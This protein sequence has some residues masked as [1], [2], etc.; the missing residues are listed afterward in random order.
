M[1]KKTWYSRT[2]LS[3]HISGQG[4]ESHSTVYLIWWLRD[5]E[6]KPQYPCGTSFWNFRVTHADCRR[7]YLWQPSSCRRSKRNNLAKTMGKW[8]IFY[9]RESFGSPGPIDT[10][11]LPL[12]FIWSLWPSTNLIVLRP[13]FFSWNSILFQRN[14]TRPCCSSPFVSR[15]GFSK[16]CMLHISSGTTNMETVNK[17]LFS[18]ILHPR[19]F[20]TLSSMDMSQYFEKNDYISKKCKKWWW[21][22]WHRTIRENGLCFWKQLY[23]PG[24]KS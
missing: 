11:R 10:T 24:E 1:V 18:L 8:N 21:D 7:W 17:W 12:I 2:S 4:Y 16:N 3:Q 14:M 22:M 9:W 23:Q 20:V 19:G 13:P 15:G 6:N 5:E